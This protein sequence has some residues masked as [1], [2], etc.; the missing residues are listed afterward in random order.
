MFLK[1]V[2]GSFLYQ[3]IQHKQLAVDVLVT[4][5]N[6]REEIVHDCEEERQVIWQELWHLVLGVGMKTCKFVLT[7]NNESLKMECK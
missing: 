7:E 6:A 1:K 5:L 3:Q 4:H 2:I